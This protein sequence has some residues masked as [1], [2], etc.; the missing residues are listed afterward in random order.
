M[1]VGIRS[2]L[3]LP[4]RQRAVQND[5]LASVAAGKAI[6]PRRYPFASPWSPTQPFERWAFENEILGT[7]PY[8]SRDEAMSIPAYARGRNLVVTSIGKLPLIECIE[9]PDAGGLDPVSGKPIRGLVATPDQ[10]TWLTQTGDGSSPQHRTAWTVDDL[11]HDGMSLWWR[12]ND[13]KG[14][15]EAAMRVNSDEWELN[16]ER[17]EVLVNG[18]PA[19]PDEVILFTGFH[20]GALVY[21]SD[22]IR[23]TKNLYRNVDKRIETP[24]QAIDL[25]QT[26]GPDM[27]D[28]EIDALV[29]M[30]AAARQGSNGG[31]GFSNQWID[32]K[33]LGANVDSQLAIE[34]RN[35]SAVDMARII[36]VH[37]G[38]LDATTPKAS[39][40]YE[41]TDGR[42]E[43]MVDFDLD[44]Y[45]VP[46]YARLSMDD[47]SEPGRLIRFD[48]SSFTDVAQPAI[49]PSMED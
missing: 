35:A 37:A 12:T 49:G 34:A 16:H 30:Y 26:G 20:E 18:D 10:P 42:N 32:V 4:V 2:A 28:A 8:A 46:I 1:H 5:V 3:G 13:K 47:V 25:H 7:L 9:T 45:M 22:A 29:A 44:L 31:V 33:E 41:T 19:G 15:L 40:N 27:T 24:I 21:G 36:G 6:D 48:L 14:G 39:L 43:E 38:N 23:S 11:I 17:R